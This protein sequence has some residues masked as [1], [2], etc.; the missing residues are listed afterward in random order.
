MLIIL[1]FVF[2]ILIFTDVKI[3][4][5]DLFFF[6]GLLLLMLM[7]RRQESM[8]ILFGSGVLARL[9]SELINKY[10]KKGTKEFIN[11]MTSTLGTI[12]TILAI[13]LI[14]ILEVKGHIGNKYIDDNSYPVEAAKYIKENIDL[15]S[16]R[17]YNEYNYGS[18]LLYEGIPVFM[19]SRADLYTPEFNKTEEYPD[20]R[21]IFSDYI[22]TANIQIYYED[23]FNKYN[24]THII[25][26]K[27]SK[28]TMLLEKDTSGQYNKIYGDDH[29]VIYERNKV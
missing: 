20:G 5:R 6:A 10:D 19:D 28:L 1:A 15:S 26:Y 22:K 12:A 29:F 7:S 21:D 11:I 3:R 13:A 9:I 16:M 27:K 4:L 8:F 23:T 14:M 2:A 25:S 17:L 24:I 18:Y